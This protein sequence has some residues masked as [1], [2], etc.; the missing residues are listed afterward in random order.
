MTLAT[1]SHRLIYLYDL[2]IPYGIFYKS[3]WS[4]EFTTLF[5][6][7]L[8]RLPICNL[9]VSYDL[10]QLLSIALTSSHFNHCQR[11]YDCL[12]YHSAF[13]HTSDHRLILQQ[14]YQQIY[15]RY[16]LLPLTAHIPSFSVSTLRSICSTTLNFRAT[17]HSKIY[18]ILITWSSWTWQWH[19]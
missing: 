6:T 18:R 9:I 11:W 8:T 1:S 10:H 12:G 14:T 4:V 13:Q 16:H 7:L 2:A 19:T 3:T 17:I 15:Q 5:A